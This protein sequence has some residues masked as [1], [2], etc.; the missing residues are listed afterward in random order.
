MIFKDYQQQTKRTLPNLHEKYLSDT[1][2]LP[3]HM[4]DIIHMR[5]G[6]VSEQD[7]LISAVKKGDLVNIAEE[8]TDML[9]YIAND[10]NIAKQ[11]KFIDSG[12]YDF[13]SNLSL[14]KEPMGTDGG[15]IGEENIPWL[16]AIVFNASLLADQAKKLLAYGKVPD[17]LDYTKYMRYLIGAINNMSLTYGINLEDSM[18]RN[19]A[20]LKSRYPESF[21]E[22]KAV[23]RDTAAERKILEGEPGE[24]GEDGII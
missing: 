12:T 22:E 20:K 3:L 21:S 11:T 2:P 9:W 7:E 4:L 10:L 1:T 24:P 8:L 17:V 19:I 15:Y 14:S 5:L 13:F 18:E 23:N 16:P 6:I